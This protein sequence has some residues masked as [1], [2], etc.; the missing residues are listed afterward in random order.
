MTGN[1]DG[2]VVGS[3]FGGG[4][5]GM[6]RTGQRATVYELAEALLRHL[7]AGGARGEVRLTLSL[8][9]AAWTKYRAEV[10][11]PFRAQPSVVVVPVPGV[12]AMEF[13]RAGASG[14]T[15]AHQTSAVGRGAIAES[16]GHTDAPCHACG[17]EGP[18]ER[19]V[20]DA[21]ALL[22]EGA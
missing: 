17:Q 7:H 2:G 4:R 20:A 21:L 18:V 9:D 11:R 22:A 12:G 3:V 8:D 5:E 14:D 1:V 15:L 10:A 19:Y 16:T 6:D 13:R